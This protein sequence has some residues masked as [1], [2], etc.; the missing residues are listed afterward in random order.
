MAVLKIT[1][2]DGSTKA[3]DVK[4]GIS[5]M[6]ILRDAD[7]DIAAVCGGC[8]SCATCHIFVAPEWSAKLP[9]LSEDEHALVES[10]ESYRPETSRLS[11]QI[12]MTPELDG[13]SFE[14]APHE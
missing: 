14:I 1:D 11:C 2:R 12:E 3:L 8:C 5:L 4:T 9:P 6:E 13:M 10:T 7:Y